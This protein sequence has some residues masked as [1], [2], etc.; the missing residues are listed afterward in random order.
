MHQTNH[1]EDIKRKLTHQVDILRDEL[2][3]AQLVEKTLLEEQERMR[4][5]IDA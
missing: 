5:E 3:T 2:K 1:Y 4:E